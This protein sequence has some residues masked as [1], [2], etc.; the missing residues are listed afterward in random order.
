MGRPPLPHTSTEEGGH[1]A[2]R[3]G[4]YARGIGAQLHRQPGD[5]FTARRLILALRTGASERAR[6]LEMP[7]SAILVAPL[8]ANALCDIL[9][10]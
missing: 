6:Y 1:Q 5:D 2:A 8:P 4:R 9:G 10:G 7:L 3:A